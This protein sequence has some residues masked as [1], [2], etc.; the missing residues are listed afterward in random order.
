M[1]HKFDYVFDPKGK[2]GLDHYEMEETLGLIPM[3]VRGRAIDETLL[4]ALANGYGFGELVELKGGSIIDNVFKYPKDS[5]L[6]PLA[7]MVSGDSVLLQYPY[8]IVAV[9]EPGKEFFVTRMD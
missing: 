3:F 4:E 8:G 2:Y 5:D 1:N 9:K 7:E 6:Y